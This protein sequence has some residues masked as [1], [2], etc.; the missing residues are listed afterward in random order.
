MRI[1]IENLLG[2]RYKLRMMGM[3]VEKCSTLLRDN[4]S[5]IVYTQLPSS[6]IKKKHNSIEFHK[7]REAVAAGYVRSVSV[8]YIRKRS[9][10]RSFI[11][12]QGPFYII[13]HHK[14]CY[15]IVYCV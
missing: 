4:I 3:E 1:A 12:L 7:A 14:G 13:T 10:R 2:L 8:T 9:Y 15:R 11:D 5:V 6:F